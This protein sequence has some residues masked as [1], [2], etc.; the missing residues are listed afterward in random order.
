V[1]NLAEVTYFCQFTSTS[2]CLVCYEE[3]YNIYWSSR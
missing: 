1:S 2:S 3:K